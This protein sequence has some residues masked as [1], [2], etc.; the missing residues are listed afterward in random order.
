MCNMYIALLSITKLPHFL[1]FLVGGSDNDIKLRSES[2]VS[3]DELFFSSTSLGK[4][5][6]PSNVSTLSNSDVSKFDLSS[7]VNPTLLDRSYSSPPVSPSVLRTLSDSPSHS[8]GSSSP[9]NGGMKTLK[10]LQLKHNQLTPSE[11]LDGLNGSPTM[12]P[13]RFLWDMVHK[14]YVCK[15][16]NIWMKKAVSTKRSVG[17][18]KYLPFR[19]FLHFIHVTVLI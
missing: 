16:I 9:I 17:V 19:Y 2:A 15:Y 10:P 8:S 18:I 5:L 11:K 1:W 12:A 3:E 6:S 14:V 7:P 4:H 13:K